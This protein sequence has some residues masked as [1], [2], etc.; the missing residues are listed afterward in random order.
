MYSRVI[1]ALAALVLYSSVAPAWAINRGPGA[2]LEPVDRAVSFTAADVAVHSFYKRRIQD[3]GALQDP[4]EQQLWGITADS[5]LPIWAAHAQ[6]EYSVWLPDA[7]TAP[8]SDPAS[9]RLIRLRVNDH[10]GVFDY[11][12]S[13]FSVGDAFATHEVTRERLIAGGLP[14]V[15]DGAELWLTGRVPKLGVRPSYRRLEKVQG[16]TN[17]VNETFGLAFDHG[18]GGKSRL[19]YLL[20][21][22][23][24][25]TWFEEAAAGNQRQSAA[26]TIRIQNPGWNVYFRNSI[27]DHEADNGPGESGSLWEVGGTLNVIQGLT[28]TPL[29]NELVRDVGTAD[30]RTS[31]AGLT[32]H[33][34]W[35]DP[36]DLNLNL[37]CNRR[38]NL[39]GTRF[40]S[41]S[42]RLNLRTPLRFWEHSPARLM[43]TATV[44]YQGMAGLANPVPEEGLSFQVT[45]EFNPGL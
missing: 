18:V 17:L 34:S 5:N 37:Q 38:D 28:V 27:F 36:V 21:S 14:G 15:G 32:L 33:T 44:G 8:A 9:N 11:G 6:L 42:A 12:A 19:M 35:I 30:L 23:D 10:V 1:G 2:D 31:T 20:E 13:V 3:N 43:M 41:T 29:V 16:T 22:T 45:F 26:A 4:L 39:D 24:V 40:E 25:S 7:R